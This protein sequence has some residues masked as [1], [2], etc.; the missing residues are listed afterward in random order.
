MDC[1]LLPRRCSLTPSVVA[2]TPIAYPCVAVW[3][4]E[5]LQQI[6]LLEI[7][8]NNTIFEISVY[9]YDVEK[10]LSWQNNLFVYLPRLKTFYLKVLQLS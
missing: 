9:I 8:G 3:V 4:A 1:Q 10:K 5:E 6:E 2:Y 7:I